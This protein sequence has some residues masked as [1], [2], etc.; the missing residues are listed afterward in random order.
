MNAASSSWTA[1]SRRRAGGN[2]AGSYMMADQRITVRFQ[3]D[4][5][6]PPVTSDIRFHLL[7]IGI[8]DTEKYQAEYCHSGDSRKHD[9]YCRNTAVAEDLSILIDQIISA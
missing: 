9:L 4:T 5:A 2:P 1:G 3:P 6:D 8:T 7:L